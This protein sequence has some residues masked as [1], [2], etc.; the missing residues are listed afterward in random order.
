[1]TRLI[2]WLQ[3]NTF[4]LWMLVKWEMSSNAIKSKCAIFCIWFEFAFHWFSL[5]SI[6]ILSL[7]KWIWWWFQCNGLP[8]EMF[9][10]MNTNFDMS[11]SSVF[12]LRVHSVQSLDLYGYVIVGISNKTYF[13]LRHLDIFFFLFLLCEAS[14]FRK[15]SLK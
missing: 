1:M 6:E 2:A 11:N 4:H 12:V 5:R 14:L 13:E 7:I 8:F 9:P 3:S 15:I 10:K